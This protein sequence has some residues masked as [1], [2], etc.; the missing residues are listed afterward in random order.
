MSV[1]SSES[2][3][4]RPGRRRLKHRRNR[5]AANGRRWPAGPARELLSNEATTVA[6]TPRTDGQ[7]G[8]SVD[9][10]ARVRQA[11]DAEPESRGEGCDARTGLIGALR[12]SGPRRAWPVEWPAAAPASTIFVPHFS[13]ARFWRRTGQ[14]QRSEYGSH[15]P[16]PHPGKAARSMSTKRTEFLVGT[17]RQPARL[18]P[19]TNRCAL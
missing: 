19:A 14:P 6:N 18:S 1:R 15:R 3:R 17:G 2:M 7:M 8:G 13:R 16:R 11:D 10:N 9:P 4:G 5:R 12:R